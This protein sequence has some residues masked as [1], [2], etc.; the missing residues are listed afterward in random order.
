MVEN[1]NRYNVDGIALGHQDPKFNIKAADI[2]VSNKT[3]S[4]QTKPCSS[5]IEISFNKDNEIAF[6]SY[7]TFQN[8]YTYA[9]TIK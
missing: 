1:Y 5:Y 2:T 6:F 3:N 9:I 4:K 8:F 7:L